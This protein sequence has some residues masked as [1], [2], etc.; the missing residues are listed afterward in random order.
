M[1]RVKYFDINKSTIK[2]IDK[3]DHVN[4]YVSDNITCVFY[5]NTNNTMVLRDIP[6]TDLITIEEA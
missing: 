2:E 5:R 6:A 4:F 1:L 3:V